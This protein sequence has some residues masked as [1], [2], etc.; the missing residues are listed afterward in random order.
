MINNVRI[1]YKMERDRRLGAVWVH[2]RRVYFAHLFKL[3]L[4][5]LI[6]AYFCWRSAKRI[7]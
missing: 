3:C 2:A 7:H 6:L 1:V 5:E 4:S